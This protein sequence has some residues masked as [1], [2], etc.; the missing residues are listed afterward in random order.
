MNRIV[1]LSQKTNTT[2]RTKD[3][4]GVETAISIIGGKWKPMILYALLTKSRRFGELQRLIPGVTQRMLTLH[5][6]E[7]EENGII[8]REIYK[9]IPPKVEYSLTKLGE[10][11]KP[12]L[13]TMEQW[14]KHYKKNAKS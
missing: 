1:S 13:V 11:V 7:L 5:L 2:E 3:E 14:G 4:C 10:T 6:R 12:L 8:H 9:Q